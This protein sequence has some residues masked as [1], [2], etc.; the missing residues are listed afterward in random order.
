MPCCLVFAERVGNDDVAT[1]T[2]ELLTL[3]RRLGEPIA[4]VGGDPSE[5]VID[6]LSAYGA[7]AVYAYADAD[8][9]DDPGAQARLLAEVARREG[10]CAVLIATGPEGKRLAGRL[11]VQL[12]CGIIT[13]AVDIEPGPVAVQSVG[14][15]AW[16]V[17]SEGLGST[18]VITVRPN[19]TSP[20]IA[21]AT[22]RVERIEVAAK[23]QD[24]AVRVVSR[25]ALDGGKR[26]ALTEASIVVSGG[27][28]VGSAEGFGLI[29][30]LADA[31]GGA[32]GA[33]RG[34]TDEH[35]YP[36]EYQVGQTGK[37]VS[38]Q[39]YLAAGISGAIQHR[40]GMQSSRT[41]VAIDTDPKAPIFQAADFGVVGDLFSVIP[42]LLEEI[43]KRS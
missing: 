39:L 9:A 1:S 6:R 14:A 36:R 23:E 41:V 37:T 4:V 13:D 30:Q 27:R 40:A 12:D 19:S 25:T 24:R 32:V 29:E 17:R 26:P 22:P 2:L 34:A 43:G 16:R 10:P 42:A 35:W 28:G 20:E 38:P 15:G 21:A 11:A 8:A 3:A 18:V 5:K 7:A 33:S 31:L